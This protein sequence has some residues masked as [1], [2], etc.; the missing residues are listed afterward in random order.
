[1][2]RVIKDAIRS[3]TKKEVDAYL[4]TSVVIV[5][6]SVGMLFSENK[7]K[8]LL[9]LLLS[10]VL[11]VVFFV[12]SRV[13]EDVAKMDLQYRFPKPEEKAIVNVE[14]EQLAQDFEKSRGVAACLAT[15]WVVIFVMLYVCT[16]ILKV[17]IGI[18]PYVVVGILAV[19]ITYM[20]RRVIHR[21]KMEMIF[22]GEYCLAE[23]KVVE[24]YTV[25]SRSPRHSCE[26]YY[27]IVTDRLGNEGKLRIT[28]DFYNKILGGYKIDLISWNRGMGFYNEMEPVVLLETDDLS[29]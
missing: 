14:I 15:L 28:E 17:R 8:G 9:L 2:E 23:V 24:R 18:V 6:V 3:L 22:N 26:H 20:V 12:A 7:S 29:L 11:T 10:S 1:M 5:F 16:V 19:G 13:V 4:L 27:V 21:T 25:T